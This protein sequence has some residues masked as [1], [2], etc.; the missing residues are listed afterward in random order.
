[1]NETTK[2][3]ATETIRCGYCGQIETL[4]QARACGRRDALL[5]P[6]EPSEPRDLG[7]RHAHDTW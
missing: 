3:P 5:P 1:M 6:D 2:R 7:G 4:A